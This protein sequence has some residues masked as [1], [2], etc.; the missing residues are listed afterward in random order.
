MS[1]LSPPVSPAL[2]PLSFTPRDLI[3]PGIRLVL[4]RGLPGSGKSTLARRLAAEMGY[5]HLEADQFFEREGPYRFDLA[6]LADAHAWCQRTAFERLAG[7]AS[8]VISNTFVTL[9]ELSSAIGLAEVLALPYR[10]IEA[11]GAWP[12]V[13]AVP[14]DALAQMRMRWE[15]LPEHLEPLA[16]TWSPAS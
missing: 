8:V 7:G 14:E 16:R 10:I 4:I 5:I 9:W 1:E 13:H 2:A 3:P 6:R 12:N 15:S 11:R